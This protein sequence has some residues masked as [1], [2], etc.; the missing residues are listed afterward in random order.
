MD[1]EISLAM[2]ELSG[3]S[4]PTLAEPKDREP[5][6]PSFHY[7]GE[8]ELDLPDE[9][10]M[11]IRF[12]KVSETSSVNKQGEHRYACTIEV[13]AICDVEGEEEP[14]EMYSDKAKGTEDALDALKEMMEKHLAE[15]SE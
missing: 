6:Y 14:D 7:D 9:G 10:E 12:R 8:K 4:V 1:K 2:D 15:E 13:Q 3:V 11:T 5:D